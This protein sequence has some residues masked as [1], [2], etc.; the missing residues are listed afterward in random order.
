MD[1][2]QS[3]LPLLGKQINLEEFSSRAYLNL[4]TWCHANGWKLAGDYYKSRSTEELTHRDKIIKF[5]VDCGYSPV[6]A[7]VDTPKDK[8][9]SLE[10]TVAMALAHE[11]YVTKSIRAL[12]KAADEA[13]DCNTENFLQWFISEQREEES[14]YIDLLDYCDRIGLG[15]NGSPDYAKKL[16]RIELEE[17]I[18]GA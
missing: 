13:E 12:Y 8:P 3:V 11:Q 1:I 10:D 6:V 2:A 17:R 14:T 4:A 9:T 15:A 5:L 18:A 7:N 16:A